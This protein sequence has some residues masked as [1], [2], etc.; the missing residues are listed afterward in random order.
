MTP[1]TVPRKPRFALFSNGSNFAC[2]VLQSIQSMGFNPE[3]LVLPEYSPAVMPATMT[4]VQN[5]CKA[6]RRLLQ[7]AAPVE[8][9]YAPLAQ[10]AQCVQ[11]LHQHAIEF[12]LVACW[13][14]LIDKWVV[15]AV[16]KAALNLH[17]SLLPS[18]PGADPISE[19][20]NSVDPRFGV[21]LHLLNSQ[22]D[23]GDIVAQ[24]ELPDPQDLYQRASL[25]RAC[26][27]LGSRL[28]IDALNGYD[29][30][31][32]TTPQRQTGDVAGKR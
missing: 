25:E 20:L 3:L 21:T 13:P 5:P 24:A 17:P 11:I 14:Y 9:A 8:I 23:Q 22:F 2:E 32:R 29:A 18:Y 19:Q 15:N 12:M 31:W 16:T 27:Q 10:Q 30:G 6:P 7:L 28:F 4:L 1:D 26:A